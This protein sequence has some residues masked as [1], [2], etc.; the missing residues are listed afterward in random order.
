MGGGGGEGLVGRVWNDAEVAWV[1]PV[2]S[3]RLC[4]V[5]IFWDVGV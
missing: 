4:G 2:I 5:G 1:D 3:D